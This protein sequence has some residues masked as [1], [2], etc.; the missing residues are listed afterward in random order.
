MLKGA[1]LD[2]RVDLPHEDVAGIEPDRARET[3]EPVR[4]D[5]HVAEVHDH[6]HQ[7]RDV[8]LGPEVK[9]AAVRHI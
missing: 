2:S 8:Q 3:E 5:S 1:H 6:R 9:G 4:H 7:A